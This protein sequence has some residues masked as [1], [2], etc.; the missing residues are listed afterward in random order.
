MK[1]ILNISIHPPIYTH[2][3]GAL[4][5]ERARALH[6]VYDISVITKMSDDE[7]RIFSV[8]RYLFKNVWIVKKRTHFLGKILEHLEYCYVCNKVVFLNN[9]DYINIEYFKTIFYCS[10]IIA[11]FRNSITFT[12][13][14]VYFHSLQERI[15]F[16]RF[17]IM[18]KLHLL[19]I[20]NLELGIYKLF[21]KKILVWG[22]DDRK[23]LVT[24][25]VLQSMIRVVPPIYL[26]HKSDKAR[27]LNTYL[28]IGSSSHSPNIDALDMSIRIINDLRESQKSSKLIVVGDWKD[29]KSTDFVQY[30]GRVDDIS[31]YYNIASMVLC[32]IVWGAG[33]KVKVVEAMSYGLTIITSAKGIR[34]IKLNSYLNTNTDT[35]LF[36]ILTKYNLILLRNGNEY[37]MTQFSPEII[38]PLYM[39]IYK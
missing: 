13:I 18:D 6:D 4:F 8:N 38:R 10:L 11:F 39:D 21:F 14:D 32:P 24:N 34:N 9:F 12:V 23:L 15:L 3:G 37:K 19:L 33:I 17:R 29:R 5:L 31:E 27:E 7:I 25:G 30:L 22:I 16:S 2:G 28:F 1:S 36:E 20:K 35:I 26:N